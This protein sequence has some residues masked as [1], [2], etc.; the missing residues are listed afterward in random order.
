M[1]GLEAIAASGPRAV[2]GAAGA[3]AGFW[4]ARHGDKLAGSAVGA[5][6]GALLASWASGE[7]RGVGGS[8]SATEGALLAPGAPWRAPSQDWVLEDLPAP[9]RGSGQADSVGELEL[10]LGYDA[11]CDP[12]S[13][14]YSGCQLD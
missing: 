6:V 4:I 10:V 11:R 9:P 5:L 3:L 12:G 13:P 1:L 2:G 7:E 8:P 14:L